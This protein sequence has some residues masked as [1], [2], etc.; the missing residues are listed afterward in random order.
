MSFLSS[1]LV[2]SLAAPVDLDVQ[3]T[4]NLHH[5]SGRTVRNVGYPENPLTEPLE[6]NLNGVFDFVIKFL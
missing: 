6:E 1:P 3:R 5:E 2:D 4:R